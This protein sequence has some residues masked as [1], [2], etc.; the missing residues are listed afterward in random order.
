MFTP[1]ELQEIKKAVQEAVKPLAEAV[2][3]SGNIPTPPGANHDYSAKKALKIEPENMGIRY[4]VVR[5]PYIIRYI[6]AD[7]DILQQ[8][9]VSAESAEQAKKMAEMAARSGGIKIIITEVRRK[10]E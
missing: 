8:I 1:E 4:N 5:H 3:A 7:P 6:E 2:Q 9:E 10:Y